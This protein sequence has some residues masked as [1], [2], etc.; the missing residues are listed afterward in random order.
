[1]KARER[2]ICTSL[3][4]AKIESHGDVNTSL[5]SCLVAF[6]SPSV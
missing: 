6:Y 2:E 3:F 4:L 1:M 5:N